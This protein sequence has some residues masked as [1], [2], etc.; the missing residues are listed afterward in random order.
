M[1]DK[2]TERPEWVSDPSQFRAITPPPLGLKIRGYS[3]NEAAH[4]R[5]INSNF[6]EIFRWIRYLEIS[7]I[8]SSNIS[9]S[10]ADVDNSVK[11]AR[12]FADSLA[13]SARKDIASIFIRT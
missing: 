13:E 11:S 8:S 1:A 4:P 2:P 6:F 10:K 5:I 7:K 12:L 9:V 3:D